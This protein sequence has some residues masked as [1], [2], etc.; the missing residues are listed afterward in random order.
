MDIFVRTITN[1]DNHV[2]IYN[3]TDSIT[4][5]RQETWKEVLAQTHNSLGQTKFNERSS[6]GPKDC[7]AEPHT[8]I[9]QKRKHMNGPISLY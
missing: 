8:H 7:Q 4:S 3:K 5:E 9:G 6:S 1:P 2:R